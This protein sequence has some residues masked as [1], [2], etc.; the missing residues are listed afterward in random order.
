MDLEKIYTSLK[1]SAAYVLMG[2][3][4]AALGLLLSEVYFG[5]HTKQ[6]LTTINEQ[7]RLQNGYYFF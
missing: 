1:N 5:V 2:T 7:T 4:M 6:N 3:G